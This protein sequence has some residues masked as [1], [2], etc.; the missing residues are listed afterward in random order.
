[1]AFTAIR[2]RM[3]R[4]ERE[5]KTPCVAQSSNIAAI[6]GLEDEGKRFLVLEL[7]EGETLARDQQGALPVDEALAYAAR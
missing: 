4:F 6:Y 5:A 3:A 1:M 7:V 2:K